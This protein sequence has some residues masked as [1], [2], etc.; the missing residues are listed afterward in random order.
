VENKVTSAINDHDAISKVVQLYVEGAAQGDVNKLKQAFHPDA[1]MF[2]RNTNVS[3][4]PFFA[5]SAK[6]PLNRG[7][8]HRAR[9]ISIQQVA[10][11]AIATVAEDGCWSTASFIDFLSLVRMDGAWKI[12]TKTFA[13]TGGEIPSLA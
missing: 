12:V 6:H 11:A 13:H 8:V 7:G 2:G 4:E 10:D 9:V 3:M 1:R 5:L